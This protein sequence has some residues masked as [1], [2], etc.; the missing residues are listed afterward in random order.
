M[1]KCYSYDGEKCFEM[2]VKSEHCTPPSNCWGTP[3]KCCPDHSS[4]D[5]DCKKDPES[6]CNCECDGNGDGAPCGTSHIAECATKCNQWANTNCSSNGNGGNGGN[7][8][9]VGSS[10]DN[11]VSQSTVTLIAGVGGA[12]LL[13]II[14]GIIISGGRG[15]RK[16][17]QTRFKGG[18]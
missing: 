6:S 1:S 10:N 2:D 9:N 7:G 3:E 18:H 8:G 13:A 4:K 12:I 17:G 14:I 5:K 11:I 15:P 16:K